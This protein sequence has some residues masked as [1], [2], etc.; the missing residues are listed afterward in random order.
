MR[1][2]VPIRACADTTARSLTYSRALWSPPTRRAAQ[3]LPTQWS[4]LGGRE[5]QFPSASMLSLDDKVEVPYHL[6]HGKEQGDRTKPPVL[7]TVQRIL[8][9]G[10]L[11]VFRD[12]V[13]TKKL[14][15]PL[16]K[17][18]TEDGISTSDVKLHWPSFFHRVSSRVTSHVTPHVTSCVTSH[19]AWRVTSCVTSRVTSCVHRPTPTSFQRRS[20]ALLLTSGKT[21]SSPRSSCERLRPTRSSPS[22]PCSRRWARPA[23]SSCCRQNLARSN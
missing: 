21:K 6:L 14:L 9:D 20:G 17:G 15:P 12:D 1:V 18:A 7:C 10:S 16:D 19:V 5:P 4:L 11:Q 2:T 3:R 8:G 22:R 13:S 23:S